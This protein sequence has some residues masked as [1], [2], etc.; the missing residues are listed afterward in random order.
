[1]GPCSRL[2]KQLLP[3]IACLPH[4]A[5]PGG[6]HNHACS[7]EGSL[8]H[9][10][11]GNCCLQWRVSRMPNIQE[12]GM[13]TPPLQSGVMPT[14]HR[15]RLLSATHLPLV[16]SSGG[17]HVHASTV[18]RSLLPRTISR[19]GHVHAFRGIR[20]FL[21]STIYRRGRRRRVPSSRGL[22]SRLSSRRGP[23]SRLHSQPLATAACP[24]HVPFL[25]RGPC[26]RPPRP[27]GS[28]GHASTGNHCL[29]PRASCVC[30]AH[31]SLP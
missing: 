19:R 13:S 28:H 26:L 3:S 21:P 30:H 15:Q 6:G 23:F 10:S 18:I 12:G 8:G 11:K 31:A 25:E 29:P 17:G 9:P 27:E 22:W 16:V 4:V 20:R 24:P 14:S 2:Q 7:L 5:Y 1:M